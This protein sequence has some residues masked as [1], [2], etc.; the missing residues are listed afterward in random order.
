MSEWDEKPANRVMSDPAPEFTKLQNWINRHPDTRFRIL[1]RCP[2]GAAPESHQEFCKYA[3]KWQILDGFDFLTKCDRILNDSVFEPLFGLPE[4]PFPAGRDLVSVRRLWREL[5]QRYAALCD[6][7]QSARSLR[8]QIVAK[9]EAVKLTGANLI[10]L[11][12]SADAIPAPYLP[13]VSFSDLEPNEPDLMQ[14]VLRLQRQIR[15]LSEKCRQ[16][17]TAISEM[18]GVYAHGGRLG[19]PEA[20]ISALEEIVGLAANDFDSEHVCMKDSFDGAPFADFFTNPDSIG[21]PVLGHFLHEH[22]H[23][24]MRF[25]WFARAIVNQFDFAEGPQDRVV[26]SVVANVYGPSFAPVVDFDGTGTE[27]KEML[28]FAF[29]LLFHLDPM[30]LLAIITDAMCGNDAAGAVRKAASAIAVLTSSG[31]SILKFVY[32]LTSLE[33]VAQRSLAV[34]SALAQFLGAWE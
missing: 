2:F 23:N 13:I 16:L 19:S 20:Q 5:R 17:T 33:C 12:A 15:V 31:R 34:R 30:R 8:K 1:L 18:S 28:D 24:S 11:L 6:V 14:P 10:S 21:N 27:D 4:H 32:E 7:H 9:V 25:G 26:N 29:D 22:Q 3:V